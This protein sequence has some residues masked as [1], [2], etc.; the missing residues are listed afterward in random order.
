MHWVV[1]TLYCV[2]AAV[3][4]RYAYNVAVGTAGPPRTVG[5]LV[6][7]AILA[8]LVAVVWPGIGI[9]LWITNWKLWKRELKR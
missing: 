8:G 3:F 7:Y 6:L 9:P 1:L 5:D 4:G 2:F